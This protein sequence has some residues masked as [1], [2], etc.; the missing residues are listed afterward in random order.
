MSRERSRADGSV[1]LLLLNEFASK[2]GATRRVDV[3]GKACSHGNVPAACYRCETAVCWDQDCATA[4][5]TLRTR[6]AS[7]RNQSRRPNSPPG[8]SS[9][10]P[11]TAELAA[12]NDLKGVELLRSHPALAL[13]PRDWRASRPRRRARRGR[14]PPPGATR[15]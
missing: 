6:S 11:G 9:G 3:C 15:G 8:E 4:C 1:F 12:S 10:G 2:K 14:C 13:L 7:K 5:A